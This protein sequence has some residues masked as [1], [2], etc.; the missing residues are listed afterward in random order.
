MNF[1]GN[2]NLGSKRWEDIKSASPTAREA[3]FDLPHFPV[4][5]SFMA[6]AVGA[7][8]ILTVLTMSIAK[9]L[10][11]AAKDPKTFPLSARRWLWTAKWMTG[12]GKCDEGSVPDM[13][14]EFPKVHKTG[15]IAAFV[16]AGAAIANHSS[17]PTAPEA[18]PL[19][20]AVTAVTPQNSFSI[21]A[22]L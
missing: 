13:L 9:D 4:F 18:S 22:H 16:M 20:P 21:A 19:R 11:I 12:F 8:V 17:H 5:G 2:K 3:A 15:F 6:G 1:D 7:P 14:S 10:A